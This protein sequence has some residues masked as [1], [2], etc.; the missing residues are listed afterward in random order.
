MVNRLN[1][2]IFSPFID[3]MLSC[4]SLMA[5]FGFLRCGEFTIKGR[6][7]EHDFL[8]VKDV[9]VQSDKLYYSLCLRCS[10]T[11]PFRQGVSIHIFNNVHTKP[12]D[13]MH[14]Y[15]QLRISQGAKPNSPLFVDN[16][17]QVLP[18]PSTSIV[19]IDNEEVPPAVGN[20]VLLDMDTTELIT[21]RVAIKPFPATN[22]PVPSHNSNSPEHQQ[23][24]HNGWQNSWDVQRQPT[25]M[26]I[27]CNEYHQLREELAR[28]KIK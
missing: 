16:N 12:V 2:S 19:E 11:D 7:E 27:I 15:R 5:F 21:N 28:S 18:Q 14:E 8:I 1:G 25:Q 13:V 3:L 6:N 22:L 4:C 20:I 23:P 10:K 24:I 26:D 17:S 9:T